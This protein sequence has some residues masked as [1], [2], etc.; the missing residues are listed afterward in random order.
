[1]N[2]TEKQIKNIV[3]DLSEEN[4][5]ACRALFQIS[6]I[7]FT[8]KVPTLAVTLSKNPMLLINMNFLNKYAITEYHVRAVLMH[9]FLHV[10]LL[11]TEKYSV[12]TPLINIALDAII[13]S[14]IH[15]RYGDRYSDFF[16]KFYKWE[17]LQCLLRPK[18]EGEHYPEEWDE[19][20]KLIYSGK[21]AVMICLNC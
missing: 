2:W 5:F 1:M 6:E 18:L 12:N 19:V 14:I 21:L 17:G 15:R 7:I 4:A 10:V 13:N 8:R 20:H 11:H 3:H 9:E 16:S